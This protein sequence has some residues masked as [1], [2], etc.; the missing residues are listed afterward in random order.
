MRDTGE[1]FGF[2]GKPIRTPFLHPFLETINHV[3]GESN[4]GKRSRLSG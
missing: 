1:K 4:D 2:M 3:H